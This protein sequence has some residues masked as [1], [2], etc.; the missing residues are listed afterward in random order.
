MSERAAISESEA[1]VASCGQPSVFRVAN[2]FHSFQSFC[3]NPGANPTLG[4]VFYHEYLQGLIGL[5]QNAS[6]RA[7]GNLGSVERGDN[8]SHKQGAISRNKAC[9]PAYG[10]G[11]L[12]K[13]RN[14]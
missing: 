1:G 12:P 8:C 7:P 11:F 5:R 3:S 14:R 13:L 6:N 2:V 9:K 4:A 10:H